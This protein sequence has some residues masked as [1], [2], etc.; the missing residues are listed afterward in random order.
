MSRRT[1]AAAA[2]PLLSLHNVLSVGMPPKAGMSEEMYNYKSMFYI[3]S[4]KGWLE[5]EAGT[6]SVD[7]SGCNSN[8]EVWEKVFDVATTWSPEPGRMNDWAWHVK[9]GINP[10]AADAFIKSVKDKA[11]AI[12]VANAGPL[13]ANDLDTKLSMHFRMSVKQV[14]MHKVLLGGEYVDIDKP[15]GFENS[16]KPIGI[17]FFGQVATFLSRTNGSIPALVRMI[18]EWKKKLP[19]QYVNMIP[20]DFV[21]DVFREAVRLAYNPTWNSNMQNVDRAAEMIKS[22]WDARLNKRA[23][24]GLGIEDANLDVQFDNLSHAPEIGAKFPLTYNDLRMKVPVYDFITRKV[25]AGGVPSLWIMSTVMNT[26]SKRSK[27]DEFFA[28][29]G[30]DSNNQKAFRTFTYYLLQT[31]GLSE[32]VINRYTKFMVD[33]KIGYTFLQAQLVHGWL[34]WE[35]VP[36]MKYSQTSTIR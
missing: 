17:F 19:A 36:G 3:A 34:D 11:N 29:S 18:N 30:G 21:E 4:L 9:N 35:L 7:K 26:S 24:I 33:Y 13:K 23:R 14:V 25:A 22:A 8:S 5:L 28:D 31:N 15:N 6:C 32:N 12:R 16:L 20:S 27:M 10:G 2:Q 1:A